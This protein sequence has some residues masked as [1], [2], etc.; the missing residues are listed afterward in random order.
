MEG[1]AQFSC[2]VGNSEV[3]NSEVGHSEVG[4]SEVGMGV[5]DQ[6]SGNIIEINKNGVRIYLMLGGCTTVYLINQE[7]PK[8]GSFIFWKGN[9]LHEQI[10]ETYMIFGP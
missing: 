10:Y 9:K 5:I 3:G 6:I 7:L 8:V 4:H 2:L 1:L